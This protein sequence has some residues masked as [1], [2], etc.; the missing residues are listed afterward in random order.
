[1][2]IEVGI[3]SEI[4]HRNFEMWVLEIK[5]LVDSQYR[6]TLPAHFFV[7]SP[8][9]LNEISLLK[10]IL[11]VLR[12]IHDFGIQNITIKEALDLTTCMISECNEK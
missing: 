1:M 10:M 6:I 4:I 8:F 9:Q 2:S 11:L 12:L 5:I 3:A 7:V